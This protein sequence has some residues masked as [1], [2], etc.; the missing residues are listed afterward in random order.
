MQQKIDQL[1]QIIRQAHTIAFLGGAGVSTESGLSD[2]RGAAA[3]RETLRRF[4]MPAEQILSHDFFFENPDVFYRYYRDFLLTPAKPNP[5]HRAL[6]RLEACGKL[7]AVITQNIDGL[8]EMAGSRHVLALHGSIHWNHCL[9]CG[10]HYDADWMR[11]G[12]GVARCEK[13]G[14]LVKPD[15]VL[16]GEPLEDAVWRGA[17]ACIFSADTLLVGGTSLQ[18]Y[19]AAG[20][21]EFFMGKHLVILNQTPTPYDAQAELILRAPIGEVLAQ[22]VAP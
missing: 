5:A 18:V 17:K 16:Y 11:A 15:V 6:V 13:C 21:L 2:F 12:A 7:N 22:A 10:Q 4:G 3:R 19:P 14:G 1:R 9:S 8:H 20:L